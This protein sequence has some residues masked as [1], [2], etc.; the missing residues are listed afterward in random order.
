MGFSFLLAYAFI[1]NKFYNIL[2]RLVASVL[3]VFKAQNFYGLFMP[4]E[5]MCQ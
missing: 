2:L 4:D 3:I 5:K 1:L